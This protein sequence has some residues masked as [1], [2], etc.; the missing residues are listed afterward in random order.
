MLLSE[1]EDHVGAGVIGRA[2]VGPC[3]VEDPEHVEKSS[4]RNPGDLVSVRRR[5]PD[6]P[7]KAR[8]ERAARTPTRG[9]TW[10]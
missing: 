2:C 5:R 1:A 10:S 4:V 7:L 8:A 9:R 6:R 3:A